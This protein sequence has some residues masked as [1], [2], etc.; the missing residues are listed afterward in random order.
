V[1]QRR[2]L[3]RL[4]TT[5]GAGAAS[6]HS[7]VAIGTKL[8]FVA[9]DGVLGEELWVFDLG[10]PNAALAQNYGQS[11]CPGTGNRTPRIQPFGLPTVGNASFAL[12]LDNALPN[13]LATAAVALAPS[14]LVI[15][16]CRVLLGLPFTNLPVV[17]TSPT[18]T[19]R[20]PLPIPGNP[21]LLGFQLF[22]QYVVVDP[23]GP[24]LGEFALSDGLWVRVGQ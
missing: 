7:L 22:A 18:G 2:Q 3:G 21:A 13:A 1:G 17:I 4:G 5:A 6:L 8:Y 16:G 9:D 14:N 23:N 20:T 12:D 15:D 10:A 11:Q 19:A 24:L